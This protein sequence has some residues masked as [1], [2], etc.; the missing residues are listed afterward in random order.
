M[1]G[2]IPILRIAVALVV[3]TAIVVAIL[4]GASATV[5]PLTTARADLQLGR[6]VFENKC[7]SCHS[8]ER[9]HALTFGPSLFEIGKTASSRRK[10]LSAEDYIFESIVKPN[11]F[12]SPGTTGEMSDR[13]AHGLTRNE[14]LSV[15]AFLCSQG[16]KPDYRA[17]V[18]LVSKW[19]PP[20]V[21]EGPSLK[22]ASLERGRELF[23]N[24]LNCSTCHT[25]DNIPGSNVLAP[26]L[27]KAGLHTRRHLRRSIEK[28]DEHIAKGFELWTVLHRDG[29]AVTGRRLP[30]PANTVKLVFLDK[31][32]GLVIRVFRHE[33][34]EDLG[35]RR[36]V[37]RQNKS[38][39]PNLAGKLNQNDMNALLDFLS[40]LR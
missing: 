11:T 18:A 30:S 13:I 19:S 17:L 3:S 31:S 12:R 25:V 37:K 2:K 5:F 28:P 15:S 26:D 16:A 14:L 4:L 20:A 7:A 32:A 29:I 21:S 40:T 27:S 24:R 34:L 1:P 39:M 33:E 23:F 8:V 38:A 35:D 6:R 22:L 36:F 9:D 10:G